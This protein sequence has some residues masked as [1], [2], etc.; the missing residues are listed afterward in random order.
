MLEQ[1]TVGVVPLCRPSDRQ[2]PGQPRGDC[3]Y[4]TRW[5]RPSAMDPL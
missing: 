5:T 3:P 2:P 1:S 4:P